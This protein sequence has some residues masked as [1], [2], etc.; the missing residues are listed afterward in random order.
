MP[1][2]TRIQLT[3]LTTAQVFAL[4]RVLTPQS[5][6]AIQ[7]L[8]KPAR[9]CGRRVPD[10]LDSLNIGDLLTLQSAA[11]IAEFIE[12]AAGILLG[13]KYTRILREQA[14]KGLGFIFW[15]GREIE[16]IG[17]MFKAISIKP[18]PDEEKAGIGTLN[19]GP[20][21]L[22]DWYAQRQ[23][24]QD[25]DDAA[26][27][28]WVRVYECMRMDNQRTAFERRLRDVLAAKTNK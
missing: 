14:D 27:I 23:G 21:G 6:A 8:P 1:K 15:V 10:N 5:R 16:R 17:K 12:H 13:V 20:F 25:Q 24:Y 26:K 7:T 19:F 22:I 4:D 3:K 11:N 9:V 28:A 2:E 18:T